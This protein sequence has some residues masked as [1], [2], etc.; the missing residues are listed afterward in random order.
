MPKSHNKKNQP[1][2]EEAIDL[3]NVSLD[4]EDYPTRNALEHFG[5]ILP[6]AG[7]IKI[8]LVGGTIDLFALPAGYNPIACV[9]AF[10]DA[11]NTV[12]SFIAY[13]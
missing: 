12:N 9:R 10:K 13:Y 4:S 2:N 3:V 6:E 8:E 5:L 7:T 1:I 11:G